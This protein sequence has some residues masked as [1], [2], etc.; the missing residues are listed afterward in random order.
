MQIQD[1]SGLG[2]WAKVD[3]YNRLHVY[4]TKISEASDISVRSKEAFSVTTPVHTFNSLNEHPWLWIRNDNPEKL[5]FFSSIVY[6][7]NGGDDNHNRIMIKKVYGS[8]PTPTERYEET[9]IVN[10]NIGSLNTPLMTVYSWDGSSGDGMEVDMTDL[11]SFST[12]MVPTSNLILNEI[13]AVV[14]GYN[15]SILFTYTPEEIGKSS[16]SAKFYFNHCNCHYQ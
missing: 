8:P 6:S 2:P 13:E 5:L 3:R 15:A 12:S 16:I 14:L 9:N 1:G 4:S 11:N 7:Y 10:L